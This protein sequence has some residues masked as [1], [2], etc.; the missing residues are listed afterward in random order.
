LIVVDASLMIDLLLQE[1]EISTL[2]P[3]VLDRKT[4][5][6][7]PDL[8]DLEV[9]QNLRRFVLKGR[10]ASGHAE[11][12]LKIY[13]DL[14]LTRYPHE[15]LLDRVWELRHNFTAYDASYVALAES[16]A[17]PLWTRDRRMAKAPGIRTEVQ[18]F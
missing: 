6:L 11:S 5:L 7:A 18:V 16:V 9:T 13:R 1:P 2:E 15:P 12:A 8:L 4:R 3:L 17:V 14:F 10:L